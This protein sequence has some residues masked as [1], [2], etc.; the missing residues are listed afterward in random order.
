MG[1]LEPTLTHMERLAFG[2]NCR[3]QSKQWV[4]GH[5][6]KV[7]EAG[8]FPV[9]ASLNSGRSSS[10]RLHSQTLISP[11]Y[12]Y[13]KCKAIDVLVAK[14]LISMCKAPG[15]SCRIRPKSKPMRTERS[16]P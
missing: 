13:V 11:S 1:K 7:P 6:H 15:S 10:P 3:K 16:P 5:M 2:E 12:P 9:G 14:C 8:D 4:W